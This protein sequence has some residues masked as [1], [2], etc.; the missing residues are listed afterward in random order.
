MEKKI[1]SIIVIGI[2]YTVGFVLTYMLYNILP[3]DSII[4]N[5]LISDIVLTLFIYLISILL[6]NASLYDPY[7]SVIPPFF[8]GFLMYELSAFSSLNVLMVFAIFVWAVRLTYNWA[9]LWHGFK[10]M[11]WRYQNFKEKHPKTYFLINLFGI[12]LFPT[13]IVFAQLAVGF[14]VI[15]L[16][17]SLNLI[18]FIGALMIIIAAFIQLIADSQMQIFKD[19]HKGQKL[20]IDEGLWKYSRHPNYFGEIIVWWGLYIIYFGVTLTLDVYILAPI[21]M[22]SMFYFISIPMMEKKILKT[23]PEY[24]TYQETVSKLIFFTRKESEQEVSLND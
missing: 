9:K 23:R 6:K 22:T 16:N 4:L 7:W 10:E 8:L 1:R 21:A 14:E 19:N 24:K 2:I 18:S 11:D 3:Y 20:C 13:L 15:L 17:P 5:L 12:Q